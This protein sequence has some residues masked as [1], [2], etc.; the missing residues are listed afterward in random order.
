MTT[1]QLRH[2]EKAR[3]FSQQIS[4][5][6]GLNFQGVAVH[7][8]LLR[9]KEYA[10]LGKDRRTALKAFWMTYFS[11]LGSKPEFVT[12]GTRLLENLK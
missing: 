10:R 3:V 5:K 9:S 4:Q 8:G 11:A 12:D 7:L 1:E 2:S 6:G